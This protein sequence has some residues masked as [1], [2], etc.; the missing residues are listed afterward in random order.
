MLEIQCNQIIKGLALDDATAA[1]FIP[2][3]LESETEH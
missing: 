3:G 2:V 1:K